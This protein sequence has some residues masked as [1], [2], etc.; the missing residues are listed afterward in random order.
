VAAFVPQ[1][2]YPFPTGPFKTFL[3]GV[4]EVL[5]ME[6]SF[7]AQFYKYLRTFLD[8]PDKVHIFKR[9]GCLNLTV[10][11]VENQIKKLFAEMHT[12]EEVL[13]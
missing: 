13:M 5:I 9:S 1:M 4:K 12:R 2:L 7:A 10:P 11:E 8:L 6:I 3:A